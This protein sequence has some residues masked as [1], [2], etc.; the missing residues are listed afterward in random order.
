MGSDPSVDA[1][2]ICMP[3]GGV[4]HPSLALGLLK[5][6]VA[7]LG[8]RCPALYLTLPFAKAVGVTPYMQVSEQTFHKGYQAVGDWVFAQALFE[9]ADLDAEGYVAQVLRR[10]SPQNRRFF[11]PLPERLIRAVLRMRRKAGPFVDRWA[12]WVARRR[13]RMI[14]FTSLFQQK[15]ASLALAKRLKAR[16]PETAI[17]FGGTDCEGVKGAALMREFPFV[18]A[19]VSG[20][21]D[22]V[23]PELVSRVLSGRALSDLEGVYT[24]ARPPRGATQG[25]CP[26]TPSITRLD[27]LPLPDFDDYFEQLEASRMPLPV[28]GLIPVE[29]S[30][31]CWW[32]EKVQC[33]FCS[34]NGPRL[35][36]RSK[37]GDRAF[38]EVARVAAKYPGTAIQMTDCVLD[39]RHFEDLIPQL[40]ASDLDVRLFYE[41][42]PDLTKEQIRLLCEAGVE[43]I[44]PGIES[45]S[46]PVLKLMRKGSTALHGVQLLKWCREYGLSAYWNVLWGFP[47]EPP[48]A[49]ARMARLVPLLAHLQPPGSA[50]PFSL[51]RFSPH[52]EQAAEFGLTDVA[53]SPAYAHIYPLKRRR[54]G[55]LAHY[56]SY[57]YRRHQPVDAYTKACKDAIVNWERAFGR[58]EL[59]CM[60]DGRELRIW[61][62]R[63]GAAEPLTALTGAQR[64]LYLACDSIQR[65]AQL[66][67]VLAED[68]KA[69]SRREVAELLTPLVERGLMVREGEAFLALAIAPG[70]FLP[71]PAAWGRLWRYQQNHRALARLEDLNGRIRLEE[72]QS[73]GRLE[74]EE[75]A[76]ALVL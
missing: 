34:L 64:R 54:V 39:P 59:F 73:G 5:A 16:L 7:P 53:P 11:D 21:G 52:F 72:P 31:G 20:E 50:G 28:P 12:D 25:R 69:R 48:E 9:D 47:G 6:A 33:T 4:T 62:E 2:L 58:S 65:L 61:D 10:P 49:Y 3:F 66:R 46:T 8:V 41:V 24:Q 1:L 30:R 75:I 76:A 15:T 27:D 63:P 71:R 40:A 70:E 26:G 45:L 36:Y 19:A 51:S 17:I 22:V 55:T 37:S 18:D 60:D 14:G 38:R 42:R 44:Q 29:T 35:G 74:Q 57:D 23:F 68:G 43:A 13:P 32:G 56:F 67:R